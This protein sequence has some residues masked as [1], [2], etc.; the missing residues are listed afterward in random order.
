MRAWLD[1]ELH[2]DASLARVSLLDHGLTV[3]DGI[4]ESVAVYDGSPFALSEHLDRLLRSAAAMEMPTP[5]TSLLREAIDALLARE[6]ATEG[7]TPLARLRLTYTAGEAPMG[8]DRGD[9]PPT[10]AVVHGPVAPQPAAAPVVTVPWRRNEQGALAGVKS[11]S[12]AE[13]VLAL[14]RARQAGAAE[15]VFGNTAGL[16]CEGTGSNVF[17]VVDGEIRTPTLVSGCLAGV[18][19]ALALTWLREDGAVPVVEV[20]AP[21][22]VLHE[23]DEVFLTSTFRDVQAVTAVDGRPVPPGE[24]VRHAIRVWASRAPGHRG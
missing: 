21:L 17:Y 5:D 19:R 1:G 24:V 15:A 9:G 14:R 16:L 2:D 4:F 12:Y 22:E 10:Y 6:A 13:N 11:T 18:T 20:D 23:A 7:T 8:S 3:G